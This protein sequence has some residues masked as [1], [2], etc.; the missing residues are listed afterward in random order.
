MKRVISAVLILILLSSLLSVG[1][2]ADGAQRI[3]LTTSQTMMNMNNM[4]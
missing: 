3:P 2:Y 4:E 1:V